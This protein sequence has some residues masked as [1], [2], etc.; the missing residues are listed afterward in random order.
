MGIF[1]L[2]CLRSG[3][4][5]LAFRLG[6]HCSHLYLGTLSVPIGTLSVPRPKGITLCFL[7]LLSLARNRKECSDFPPCFAPCFVKTTKARKLRRAVAYR[8][9]FSVSYYSLTIKKPICQYY[10][11]FAPISAFI[12]AIV[13]FPTFPAPYFNP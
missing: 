4:G 11:Q 10:Y 5:C 1:P 2:P 6:R 12:F 9:G 3:S 7:I 8:L 13:P